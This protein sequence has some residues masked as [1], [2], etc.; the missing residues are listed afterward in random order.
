MP[1]IYF[2]YQFPNRFVVFQTSWIVVIDPSAYQ[3]CFHCWEDWH[4]K[5][6]L[7]KRRMC[8]LVIH[9]FNLPRH[10]TGGVVYNGTGLLTIQF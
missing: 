6:E 2:S 3:D 1:G 7:S 5:E 10:D 4:N 8:G 9:Q